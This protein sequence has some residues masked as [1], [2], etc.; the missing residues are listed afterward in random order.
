MR[1]MVAYPPVE[2]KGS[3]MLTQNRQFQWFHEPSYL[4]PC[5]P[6]SAATWLQ[7]LGHDV[8]WCDAIAERRDWAT[9]ERIL[10]DTKPEL[11]AMETKTPVVRQH[12][13]IGARIKELVP[14]C[15]TV[16]MGDHVTGNP[17]ETAQQPGIDYALMGGHY[18]F[19]LKRLVEHLSEGTELGSGFCYQTADGEVV[20]TGPFE[21]ESKGK[22]KDLLLLRRRQQ[23]RLT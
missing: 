21:N 3:P 19:A 2:G 9:F 15:R 7:Q 11:V 23:R 1:V 14:G 12:W 16:L 20:N 4:Y 10:Q 6:A 13:D 5:V 17:E 18:D 8:T 22:L